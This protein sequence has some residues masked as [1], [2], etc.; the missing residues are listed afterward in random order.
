MHCTGMGYSGGR[1]LVPVANMR[2]VIGG[3]RRVHRARGAGT[4]GGAR[5]ARAQIVRKIMHERGVSLP[6]ASSIVKHEGLY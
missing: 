6:V 2:G 3:R 4:S 1:H 5:H